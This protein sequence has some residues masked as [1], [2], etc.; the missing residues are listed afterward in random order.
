MARETLFALFLGDGLVVKLAVIELNIYFNYLRD[1]MLITYWKR[2]FSALN[3][4]IQ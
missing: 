4:H 3:F 2:L 1:D